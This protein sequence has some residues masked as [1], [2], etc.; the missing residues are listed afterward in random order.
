VI[1][2]GVDTEQFVPSTQVCAKP[3]A[4]L[5]M[6]FTGKMDFR[7]N[8]D[9]MVWFCKEILPRVRSEIPL[10]HLV[11]VGQKPSAAVDSL[12]TRPG[13]EVTGAVPDI[14]PF[15]ADAAVYV[16]PLRMGSGTRLKVLE[17]MAMGK[18]IVS[19]RRG[20]EGIDVVPGRDVLIA[21]SPVDFARQ[22]VGLLRDPARQQ[23]LGRAARDLAVAKYDWRSI[24]GAFDAIYERASRQ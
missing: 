22:V 13:V 11:I 9:G 21:D 16:V 1:P 2:N 5:S 6:V 4:E 14:R 8:V 15:V 12:R 17:A 10:A 18:A 19:T 7:P 3:L 24:V 20:V 23:S